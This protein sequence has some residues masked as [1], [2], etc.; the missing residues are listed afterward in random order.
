MIF[1][2]IESSWTFLDGLYYCFI[3]L[4]TIGLGDYV[5]GDSPDQEYRALYKILVTG[6]PAS[7]ECLTS[8]WSEWPRVRYTVTTLA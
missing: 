1:T 5:P 6:K 7:A 2:K 3:S 4:T 8:L